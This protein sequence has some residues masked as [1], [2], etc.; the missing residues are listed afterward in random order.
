[1][2]EETFDREPIPWHPRKPTNAKCDNISDIRGQVRESQLSDTHTKQLGNM[3]CT[4]LVG[5]R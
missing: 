1:M 2:L 3:P 5:A 4:F